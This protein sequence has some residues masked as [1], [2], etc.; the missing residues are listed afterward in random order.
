MGISFDTRLPELSSKTQQQYFLEKFRQGC[1]PTNLALAFDLS[2]HLNVNQLKQFR[3]T[4]L[5]QSNDLQETFYRIHIK[6]VSVDPKSTVNKFEYLFKRSKLSLGWIIYSSSTQGGKLI[7]S[8]SLFQPLVKGVNYTGFD[9][10]MPFTHWKNYQYQGCQRKGISPRQVFTMSA[11]E[12]LQSPYDK[13]KMYINNEFLIL[14]KAEFINKEKLCK[15]VTVNGLKKVGDKY[16]I[17]NINIFDY[18]SRPKQTIK[19]TIRK[20]AFDQNFD[21]MIF[22]TESPQV[23]PDTSSIEYYLMD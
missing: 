19:F 12:G 2:I 6:E 3:G 7:D 5:T 9:L 8:F 16:F 1:V 10:L 14:N 21:P 22:G 13:V 15:K 17:K 20:I 23:F 4:V 11:P 18:T